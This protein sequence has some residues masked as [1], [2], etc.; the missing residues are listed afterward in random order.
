MD[1]E[2]QVLS[3]CEDALQGG[4]SDLEPNMSGRVQRSGWISSLSDVSAI[5]F[6]PAQ[7]LFGQ[8]E[9]LQKDRKISRKQLDWEMRG[10]TKNL[11]RSLTAHCVLRGSWFFENIIRHKS[12][13]MCICSVAD[14]H[15]K[16]GIVVLPVGS[17]RWSAWVGI[18]KEEVRRRR[19]GMA[20]K[21]LSKWASR[22]TDTFVEKLG[23]DWSAWIVIVLLCC[24]RFINK[25]KFHT[26][27]L[28][29]N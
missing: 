13:G 25:A 4:E 3:S 22:I 11:W 7:Y 27:D 21:H 5:H 28:T 2:K 1:G 17:L 18:A 9:A 10:E 20:V 16:G 19:H 26:G 14:G 24:M 6:T 29:K 23:K 15:W 8:K 12:L